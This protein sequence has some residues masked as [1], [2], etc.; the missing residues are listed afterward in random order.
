M[1]REQHEPVVAEEAAPASKVGGLDKIQPDRLRSP[2]G[3]RGELALEGRS[4][5][6]AERREG[7][8]IRFGGSEMLVPSVS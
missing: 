5:H 7:W 3:T 6:V 1:M 8:R 2:Y 4:I